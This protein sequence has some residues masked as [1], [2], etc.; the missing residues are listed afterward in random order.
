MNNL[1]IST[2][3]IGGCDDNS[4]LS[5]DAPSVAT[6]LNQW[7]VPEEVVRTHAYELWQSGY[8][9]NPDE[10]WFEAERQIKSALNK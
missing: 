10:N 4:L 1:N 7:V 8:S 9:Q 5:I 3:G 2:I 6:E